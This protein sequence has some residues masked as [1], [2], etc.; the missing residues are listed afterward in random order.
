M[1]VRVERR[2]ALLTY[3]VWFHSHCVG[4]V[5]E[6]AD[7]IPSVLA[8]DKTVSLEVKAVYIQL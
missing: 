4:D 6:D 1:F 8:I 2:R 7:G 5:R 3:A